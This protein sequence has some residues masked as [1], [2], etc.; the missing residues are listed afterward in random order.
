MTELVATFKPK[1]IK[2][3]LFFCRLLIIDG[4]KLNQTWSVIDGPFFPFSKDFPD[5]PDSGIWGYSGG[6][7]VFGPDPDVRPSNEI[8]LVFR[9]VHWNFRVL[10]SQTQLQ[11]KGVRAI[12]AT[13][14]D[15]V[16]WVMGSGLKP[17]AARHVEGRDRWRGPDAHISN[18]GFEGWDAG[19]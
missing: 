3:W 14:D 10:C 5:Q 8:Y 1:R 9:S 11:G 7:L 19:G 15:T 18:V 12:P 17:A 2:D 6:Q 16:V 13:P 4:G